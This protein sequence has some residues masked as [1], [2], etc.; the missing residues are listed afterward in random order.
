MRHRSDG[1]AGA[2][3]VDAVVEEG[4]GD[5][6]GQHLPWD[7]RDATRGKPRRAGDLLS[8]LLCRLQARG[9]L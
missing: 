4:G 7:L 9:L 5:S 3:A 2:W 8:V 1:C 6:R